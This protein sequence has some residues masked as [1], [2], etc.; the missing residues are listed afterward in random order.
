MR[1]ISVA[2]AAVALGAIGALVPTAV[3]QA[4]PAA[5]PPNCAD[6]WPNATPGYMYAYRD[7]WCEG[8]LGKATSWD[9]NWGNS[10][11]SFQG[12]DD[13]VASSVLNKGPTAVKF[14]RLPG[15]TGG[16]WC[17]RAAERWDGS[18]VDEHFTGGIT[19]GDHISSHRWV[20][21]SSCSRFMN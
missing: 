17:L 12:N 19:V 8:F 9:E 21:A 20:P 10:S 16:S 3:S 6:N 7:L 15:Y 18:L 11:R 5:A 1:K 13:N 4:D 2:V 14:F